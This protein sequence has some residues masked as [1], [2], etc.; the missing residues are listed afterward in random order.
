[1]QPKPRR[2][3]PQAGA[4]LG[5]RPTQ[6]VRLRTAGEQNKCLEQRCLKR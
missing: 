2:H 5:E 6:A 1:M 3:E 4:D